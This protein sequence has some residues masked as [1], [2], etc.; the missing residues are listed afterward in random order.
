MC[1][2]LLACSG[3]DGRAFLPLADLG[4]E[5]KS[6]IVASNAGDGFELYAQDLERFERFDLETGGRGGEVFLLALSSTLEALGVPEGPLT[7]AKPG[8]CVAKKLPSAEQIFHAAWAEGEAPS[9]WQ[10]TAELPQSLASTTFEAPCPCRSF[11]TTRVDVYDVPRPNSLLPMFAGGRL[12]LLGMQSYVITPDTPGIEP[13]GLP[14]GV[15]EELRPDEDNTFLVVREEQLDRWEVDGSTS[16]PTITRLTGFSGALSVDG[17]NGRLD[18]D[19]YGTDSQR[20]ILHFDGSAW[21][22]IFNAPVLHFGNKQRGR[23][24]WTEQR[25][26]VTLVDSLSYAIIEPKGAP[27]TVERR[28]DAG[29][30]LDIEATDIGI[31]AAALNGE[32]SILEGDELHI[33]NAGPNNAL[34]SVRDIIPGFGGVVALADDQIATVVEGGFICPTTVLREPFAKAF[35]IAVV[36]DG[37]V[38]VGLSAEDDVL[39]QWLE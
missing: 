23:V 32:I 9:E 14:A 30:I 20:R 39:V 16:T 38:A 1:L 35:A 13:V 6:I 5:T 27:R 7:I 15:V 31:V 34:H 4:P 3:G 11:S 28:L 2:G 18:R 26:V 17:P 21:T 29:E 33:L 24:A 37:L 36:G 25:V 19:L 22:T 8:H 12:Y 10:E